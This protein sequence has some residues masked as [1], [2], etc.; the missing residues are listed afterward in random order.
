VKPRQLL[1]AIAGALLVLGCSTI[2]PGPPKPPVTNLHVEARAAEPVGNVIPVMV[3][4]E[5]Q[6]ETWVQGERAVALNRQGQVTPPLE[7]EEAVS[8]AGGPD[9]LTKMVSTERGAGTVAHAFLRDT[10]EGVY[11]GLEMG[12]SSGGLGPYVLILGTAAGFGVGLVHS[13]ILAFSEQRRE[14]YEIRINQFGEALGESSTVIPGHS[15]QGYLFFPRQDYQGLQLLLGGHDSHGG[16]TC[17]TIRA[18]WGKDWRSEPGAT[19][20]ADKSQC[21]FPK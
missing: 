3:K 8:E 16:A 21:F 20:A 11:T 17:E 12:K 18:P 14:M 1:I 6:G 15:A 9:K 19:S 10:G 2:P 4:I 5:N 7:V 13:V